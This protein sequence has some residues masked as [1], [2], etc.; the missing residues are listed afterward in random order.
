MAGFAD[1]ALVQL[2]EPMALATL[3]TGGVAP[4]FPHLER[5]VTEV[6]D[7]DGVT[8]DRITS[9]TV[10]AVTPMRALAGADR[11][12]LTWQQ[13]QPTYTTSDLRGL[14]ER[15]GCEV[16]AD[17][18]ATVRLDAVVAVDPGGIESAVTRAIDHI[19]SLDDFRS[20]FRYL[21][22][23]EF[24]ARRRISTVEELRR[25]AD[26]LL[27][28]VRLHPVPP[29]DPQDPANVRSVTL[30]LAL[31]VLG[32]R[33][34]TAGL[35][36]ARRLRA[37]GAAGPPGPVDAVFGRAARPFAVAVVL[38]AATGGQPADDAVDALFAA[39]GVLPLTASPP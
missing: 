35:Q 26:Y 21:D 7:T 29:F 38:P 24:L 12:A 15:S 30:D 32:E 5:L 10:L 18:Y 31:A 39:A 20:R 25:S 17:L 6:Y 34:L 22:L 37:A 28:E 33:D 9:A 4:P 36:A 2:H 13:Q 1:R 14:V 19:T 23:E 27:A 3:L 11:V 16:W 8:L